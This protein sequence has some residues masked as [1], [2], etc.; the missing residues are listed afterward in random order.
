M[1]TSLRVERLETRD[2]PSHLPV[3]TENRLYVTSLYNDLLGRQPDPVGL[4]AFTRALDAGASR[5]SVALSIINS[6]EFT[7][8]FIGEQYQHFLGRRATSAEIDPWVKFVNAGGNFDQLQAR[9]I[10][11]D[12]AFI[13][14]GTSNTAWLNTLYQKALG[15]TIDPTALTNGLALLSRGTSRF[16]IALGVFQSIE[17]DRLTAKGFYLDFLNRPSD[18]E[19]LPGWWMNLNDGVKQQVVMAQFLATE[20]YVFLATGHG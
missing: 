7:R 18:P 10:S 16:S 17:A 2:V 14:D 13:Q 6:I 5:N 8:S 12:E 1:K 20:E 11:S 3:I 4:D 19:G 15:R 9:L